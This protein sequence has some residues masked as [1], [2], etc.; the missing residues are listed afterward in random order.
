MKRSFLIATVF[1]SVWHLSAQ[2]A[3]S[4]AYDEAGNRISRTIVFNTSS[5]AL[6]NTEEEEEE[7]TAAVSEVVA[8]FTIRIYPNPT[9]GLLRV[10]IEGM[11]ENETA[12]L[13]LY[14]TSGTLIRMLQDVSSSAE[15]DLGGQP[16]GIYLLRIQIGAKRSE[17]KIIKK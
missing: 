1:L 17:W 4:F 14:Q 16:A 11:P 13:A 6:R 15:I 7:E 12:Q 8:D 2:D 9:E 5:S 3:V 10:S